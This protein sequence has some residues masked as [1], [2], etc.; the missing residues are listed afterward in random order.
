MSGHE[1]RHDMGGSLVRRVLAAI[2][3]GGLAVVGI[4]ACS[5]PSQNGVRIVTL[6]R[7]LTVALPPGA[8]AAAE[9]EP[10]A[11]ESLGSYGSLLK[12]L[13][14]AVRVSV[15]RPAVVSFHVKA[16]AGTQPFLASLANGKWSTV[17]STYTA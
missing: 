6:A 10:A 5:A 12:V 14:P 7:N 3:A 11:T 4:G 17:P 2:I 9:P 1:G 8:K 16:P 13:A 15:T